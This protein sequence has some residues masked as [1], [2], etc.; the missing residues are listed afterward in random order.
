MHG[1]GDI[2]FGPFTQLLPNFENFVD[3]ATA[4]SDAGYP[5]EGY[6]APYGRAQFVMEY[7]SAKVSNPPESYAELSAWVRA[8]PGRFTYPQPPDFTR[9]GLHSSGLLCSHRRV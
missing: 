1:R 2:L 4:L 9:F 3:P 7:D 5:V 8:N 6:E